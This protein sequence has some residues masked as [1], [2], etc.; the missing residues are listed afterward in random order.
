M[1]KKV[2]K[3]IVLLVVIGVFVLVGIK[4]KKKMAVIKKRMQHAPV[5]SK[6]EQLVQVTK[7]KRGN[8]TVKI[9]YFS[10]IETF[11]NTMI[12]SQLPGRI[13][14]LNKNEG[15]F[16]HTGEVIAKL[17]DRE[18]QANLVAQKEKEASLQNTLLATK[19]LISGVKTSYYRWKKEYARDS[20]LRKKGVISQTALDAT[21]DKYMKAKSQYDSLRNK[22]A[23]INSQ[24]KSI[25]SSIDAIKV[26]ISYT[27]IK[28]PFSGTIAQKYKEVGD[29]VMPSQ[30]IY[31]LIDY[32]HLKLVWEAVQ[33]DLS[34]IQKGLKVETSPIAIPDLTITRIYPR[35]TPN[36]MAKIECDFTTHNEKLIPGM[37]ILA[38]LILKEYKNQVIIPEDSLIVENGK[39]AVFVYNDNKKPEYREVKVA[40]IFKEKAVIAQGL[41]GNESLV[42]GSYL[43]WLRINRELNMK[44]LSKEIN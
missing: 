38:W 41:N 17:D 8:L 12:S 21:Y 20:V 18:L 27:V 24:L 3:V 35:L 25:E 29:V 4:A 26:K 39:Y 36:R 16:V 42:I 19:S 43:Q 11:Q 23:S 6:M 14:F 32:T 33:E 15:D 13:I 22:I 1:L 34:F 31:D 30:P 10:H 44:T 40:R 2:F 28:A 37:S 7:A 5:F 9:P